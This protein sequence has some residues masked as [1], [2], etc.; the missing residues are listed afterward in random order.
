M[1]C[2]NV[3]TSAT[4][5]LANLVRFTL[6]SPYTVLVESPKS[7]LQSGV[8]QCLLLVVAH[9]RRHMLT[10]AISASP[11]AI[12]V[13]VLLVWC[14]LTKPVDV[15]RKLSKRYFVKTISS[16]AVRNVESLSNVVTFVKRSV[17]LKVNASPLLKNSWRRDVVRDAMSLGRI[18]LT[19]ARLLVTLA[20][21]VPTL[22]VRL[23]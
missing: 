21:L 8:A 13:L 23:K 19:D 14:S 11:C 4:L 7:I 10:V 18:V 15:A 12:M 16:H 2:I 5:A 20:S 22:H 1:A 9:A 3:T 17:M 6:G